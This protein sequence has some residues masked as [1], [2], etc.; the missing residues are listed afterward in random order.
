MR[1]KITSPQRFGVW[2]AWKGRCF[3]CREHVEFRS[4]HVDHVIPLDAVSAP[5]DAEKVR[6]MYALP[7][8]FGFD[9][10]ENWVPSCVDCNSKKSFTL[11]DPSPNFGFNLASVRARADVA[12]A[13]ADAIDADAHKTKLLVQVEAA[14]EQ[15]SLTAADIEDLFK[16]LPRLTKKADARDQE[17]LQIAPGWTVFQSSGYLR[18][19]TDGTRSGMTSTSKDPSWIC[20]RCG[21]KGPWNGII[22]LS[23]GN[24]EEPD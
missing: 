23:C 13:I 9:C 6:E 21:N 22:C 1:R 11:I 10:Y 3:W 4:S 2:K 7:S 19:V 14:F 16:G 15:G 12:K 5:E 18:V 8:T 17:V 24:R 20:S